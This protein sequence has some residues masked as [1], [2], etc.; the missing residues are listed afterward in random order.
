MCHIDTLVDVPRPALSAVLNHFPI[1]IP[2]IVRM[3]QLSQ[4]M[5][6]SCWHA[7]CLITEMRIDGDA[8]AIGAA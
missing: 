5:I 1:C 4:R 3:M 7:I 2:F 8:A 6:E